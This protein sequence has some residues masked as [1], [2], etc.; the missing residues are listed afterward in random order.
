MN[1]QHGL[2][3]CNAITQRTNACAEQQQQLE[4]EEQIVAVQ[5]ILVYVAEEC[6]QDKEVTN[7]L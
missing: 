5:D 1:P 7:R 3:K 4:E 6:S 2:G